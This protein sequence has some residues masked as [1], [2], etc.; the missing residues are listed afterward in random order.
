M[1]LIRMGAR[2]VNFRPFTWFCGSAIK[3][4]RWG[5]AQCADRIIFHQMVLLLT[6]GNAWINFQ[7][8]PYQ[9]KKPNIRLMNRKPCSGMIGKKEGLSWMVRA[10]LR[11]EGIPEKTLFGKLS[12]WFPGI[13]E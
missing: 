2:K 6:Q 13:L 1:I 10:A 7:L 3:K 4:D 5:F 9:M 12:S 8:T 11:E